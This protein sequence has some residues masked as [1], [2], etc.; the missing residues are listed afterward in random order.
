MHRHSR[1]PLGPTVRKVTQALEFLELVTSCHAFVAKAGRSGRALGVAGTGAGAA[2]PGVS[3]AR[4]RCHP[5]P[6]PLLL[7]VPGAS[8]SRPGTGSTPRTGGASSAARRVA[9]QQ[10]RPAQCRADLPP[11]TS[12]PGFGFCTPK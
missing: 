10:H 9:S 4:L 7:Q 5:F 6:K 3:Q 12:S 2:C 1:A 11:A 8:N